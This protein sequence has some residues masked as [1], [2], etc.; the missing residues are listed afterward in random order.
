VQH[1][2]FVVFKSEKDRSQSRLLSFGPALDD[3]LEEH[4][5]GDYAMAVV[6]LCLADGAQQAFGWAV[7]LDTYKV[8]G[9][10]LV[11]VWLPTSEILH[12]DAHR[13]V[14]RLLHCGQLNQSKR[15]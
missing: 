15:I 9:L 1:A 2:I 5:E 10:A 11:R 8:Q 7:C 13:W 6:S 12:A 14:S 3:F 4:T